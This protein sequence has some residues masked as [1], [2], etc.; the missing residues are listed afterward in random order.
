MFE[1]P[2]REAEALRDLGRRVS[3]YALVL[4]QLLM[5]EDAN[6]RLMLVDILAAIPGDLTRNAIGS[7][8]SWSALTWYGHDPEATTSVETPRPDTFTPSASSWMITSPNAS[9]PPV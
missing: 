1:A 6:V 8:A 2:D 5:H 4:L 3:R 9:T 7:I